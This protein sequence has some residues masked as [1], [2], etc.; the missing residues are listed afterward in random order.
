MQIRCL[1]DGRFKL[2]EGPVWCPFDQSLWWVNMVDHSAVYRMAW[3]TDAPDIFLAPQPVTGIA[4][5]RDGFVIAGSVGGLLR[6]DPASGAFDPILRLSCDQPGNRCNEIG[7][8]PAGN[9]WV[10]TMTDNLSGAAVGP[11]DGALFLIAPDGTQICVLRGLGI[12]NTLVW[13]AEG[14][15]LTADSLTGVIRRITVAPDGVVERVEILAEGGMGVPDGSALAADGT[16]WNARW[17]AGCLLG[18]GPDGAIAGQIEVP[19][20]NITSACFAGPDLE[21]LIVTSSCWGLTTEDLARKPHAGAVFA[22][23]DVGRGARMQ[24]RFA[25]DI[26]RWAPIVTG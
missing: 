25:A 20:G 23:E 26:G 2:A 21:T 24:P 4:L 16:L 18:I 19:G 1:F 7:V 3:G 22:L 8:D 17:S 5:A 6:L 10:G 14:R 9:L 13:D 15:L 12:P 11:T